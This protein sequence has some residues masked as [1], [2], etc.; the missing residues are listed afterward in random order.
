[1]SSPLTA[2]NVTKEWNANIKIETAIISPNIL[3]LLETLEL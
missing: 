1:M 2:V 3:H